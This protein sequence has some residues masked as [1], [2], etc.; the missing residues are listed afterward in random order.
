MTRTTPELAPPLQTSTPIFEVNFGYIFTMSVCLLDC[1]L[2][3]TAQPAVQNLKIESAVLGGSLL[4]ICI[5]RW[6]EAVI[7]MEG[8]PGGCGGGL[9]ANESSSH[10]VE[11]RRMASQFWSGQWEVLYSNGFG[12]PPRFFSSK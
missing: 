6:W 3:E 11:R 4:D 7:L 10:R 9:F 5:G 12:N 8:P 2:P 1:L